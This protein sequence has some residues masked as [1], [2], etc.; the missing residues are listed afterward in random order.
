LEAALRI[1]DDFS[2]AESARRLLYAID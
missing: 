2:E 1:S